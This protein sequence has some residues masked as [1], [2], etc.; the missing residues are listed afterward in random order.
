LPKFK[1]SLR[2]EEQKEMN[3]S[4]IKA[5]SVICLLFMATLGFASFGRSQTTTNN[6]AAK[7]AQGENG[8]TMQAL[9]NEVRQLRLAIQ[10]SNLGAYH[11]Q[12]I[13]E[14]MRTQRQHV[15]RLTERLR[16]V[17][18]RIANG[19]IP[20]AEFQQELKR[21]EGRLSQERE[22]ERRQDMEEQQ[23]MFKT[24]LAALAKEETRLQEVETQLA[25]QLQIEQAKLAELDDQ[26]DALRRELE[27]PPA[28]NKQPQGEKRP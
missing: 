24:R 12:L 3:M 11:T 20:Q 10:K 15:D 18:E 4:R 13:I 5:I 2:D 23:D 7:V 16:D 8:P 17:R 21:I 25:A 6:N 9:L 27:M 26:L 22:A 28:E 1:P 19:K 14:R